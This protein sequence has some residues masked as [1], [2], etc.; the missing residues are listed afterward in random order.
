VGVVVGAVPASFGAV[1]PPLHWLSHSSMS[2]D[3]IVLRDALHAELFVISGAH[4][5]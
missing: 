1:P 2:H 3:K 5:E 4:D